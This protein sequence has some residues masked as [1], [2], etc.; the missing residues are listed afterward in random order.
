MR[1]ILLIAI[2]VVICSICC[3]PSE[4]ACGRG[5]ARGVCRAGAR[6]AAAVM[7]ENEPT[8]GGERGVIVNTASVAAFEGQIGQAA[9]AASK[10]ALVGLSDAL[11]A[12]LA[13]V[14]ASHMD[15]NALDLAG[16]AIGNVKIVTSGAGAA[17]N[18]VPTPFV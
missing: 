10:F 13:P 4:A 5:A 17:G 3:A 12:E 18:R 2:C 11:R 7:K 6:L 8:E 9:Y 16:K 14:L 1:S 15:V